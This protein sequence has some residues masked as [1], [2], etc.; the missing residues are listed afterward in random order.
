[1]LDEVRST[2]EYEEFEQKLDMDTRFVFP[3]ILSEHNALGKRLIIAPE[4]ANWLVCDDEE[5]AAFILLRQGKSINEAQEALVSQQKMSVGQSEVAVSRLIG[6]VLGKEFLHDAVVNEKKILDAASLSLTAGCNL[7][8]STC[9]ARATVPGLD[10]CNFDHWRKFLEVFRNFGGEFV[11]LTGGEPMLNP[12]CFNIARRAKELGFK[13]VLLTNGTLVTKENA[14]ILGEWFD[15]VQISIDGPT[16]DISESIRGKGTFE[17]ALSAL[18]ELNVYPE[19]HLSVAM[20]PTPT[21]LPLFRAGFRQFVAMIR[22]GINPDISIRVTRRLTEGRMLPQLSTSDAEAF[23]KGVLA[24]CDNQLEEDFSVKLDTV[25]IVPNR[26]VFG[27]GLAESF[28]IRANGNVRLCAFSSESFGNIKDIG[29][30]D[31]KAFF[32][33][34][35]EK[36]SRL[37]NSVRVEKVRPCG[38]CDLR[39]FCGG[40]CRRDNKKEHGSPNVCEC[41]EA[42]KKEWYERLV[43]ISPYIVEPLTVEK[44]GKSNE[45]DDQGSMA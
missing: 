1:M 45:K 19:C 44:G 32:S 25:T 8:C 21:T 41:G 39:Y 11:T 42:I 15:E 34:L 16:A 22:G 40:K 28:M 12:D 43:R 36:L 5:Y 20:T 38:D 17:K 10:E 6:Q 26:R 35:V 13:V 14:K 7:R 30:G 33:D 3:R 31:G 9:F 18:R 37:T 29:N 4:Q 27:C 24:L 23:R 2:D